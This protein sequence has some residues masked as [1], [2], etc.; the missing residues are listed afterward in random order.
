MKEIAE[1]EIR[2]R[3]VRCYERCGDTGRAMVKTPIVNAYS[4]VGCV[5][6]SLDG[7][8]PKGYAIHIPE[9]RMLNIYDNHGR[10]V[11][12]IREVKVIP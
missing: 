9:L 11:S 3:M 4:K 8:P 1:S 2:M 6:Y 10:R 12:I 7:S 5:V